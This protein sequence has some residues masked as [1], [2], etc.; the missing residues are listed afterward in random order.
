MGQE[1]TAEACLWVAVVLVTAI[2]ALE[3]PGGVW[4]ACDSFIGDASSTERSDRP[5]FFKHAGMVFGWSGDMRP[6]QLVEYGAAMRAIRP[7]EDTFGYLV[8]VVVESIRAAYAKGLSDYDD[9]PHTLY[10]VA[11][12]G[13]A[14][15]IQS[16]LSV[17]RTDHGYAA[18]GAGAEHALVALAA[19]EETEPRTRVLKA[20]RAVSLH[21]PK[22]RGRFHDVNAPS[23]E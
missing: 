5:K 3:H 21:H 15:T 13:R 22:V 10:I 4:L 19:C 9:V 2:V 6:A 7:G 16:D 12:R 1:L 11:V 23:S 17:V 20:L 14:Y 18:I 8:R